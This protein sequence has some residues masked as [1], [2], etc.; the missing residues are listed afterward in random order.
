MRHWK[1]H[2]Q[3]LLCS[4]QINESPITDCEP[5]VEG[6]DMSCVTI[7]E[8]SRVLKKIKNG[9]A[10]GHNGIT[11]EMLKFMG[12]RGTMMLVEIYKMVW[13]EE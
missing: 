3:E 7:E 1:E 5:V 13:K 12:W 9:K 6:D 2:F 11:S 4:N 8:V 10:P